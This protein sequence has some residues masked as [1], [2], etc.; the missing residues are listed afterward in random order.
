MNGHGVAED[1]AAGLARFLPGDAARDQVRRKGVVVG[2]SLAVVLLLVG[3]FYVWTRMQQVQIGY[4]ISK[5]EAMNKDLK[6]RKRE[7]HLELSS[8]QSPRELE[9]KA[10][11]LGLIYPPVGKVVHVP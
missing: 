11:K 5:L 7:L 1:A 10:R 6:N 2:M 4:E 9:A 8:L 3:L